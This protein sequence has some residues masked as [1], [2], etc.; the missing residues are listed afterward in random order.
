MSQFL[1]HLRKAEMEGGRHHDSLAVRAR[2]F[3][4]G[5]ENRNSLKEQ[6]KQRIKPKQ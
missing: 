4:G 2:G 1:S 5:A 6:E 3:L